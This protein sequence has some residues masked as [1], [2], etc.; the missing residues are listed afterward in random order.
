MSLDNGIKPIVTDMLDVTHVVHAVGRHKAHAKNA[1]I[2][3]A[4]CAVFT[5]IAIF[6]MYAGNVGPNP[7]WNL[8]NHTLSM[9]TFGIGGAGLGLTITGLIVALSNKIYQNQQLKIIT[10]NHLNGLV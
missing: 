3:A 9:C 4:V 10:S 6:V 8:S 7:L 1:A 5:A 2:F